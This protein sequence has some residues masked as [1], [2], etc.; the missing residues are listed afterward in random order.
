MIPQ[1]LKT[2]TT[3]ATEKKIGQISSE[4]KSWENFPPNLLGS[5]EFL[6][7]KNNQGETPLHQTAGMLKTNKF[8]PRYLPKKTSTQ[9]GKKPFNLEGPESRNLIFTTDLGK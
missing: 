9:K 7:T 6:L 5:P 4:L 2:L 8:L 3:P 1:E